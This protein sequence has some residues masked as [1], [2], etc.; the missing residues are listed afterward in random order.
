M[1]NI[2]KFKIVGIEIKTSNLNGRGIQ[3]IGK[4]WAEFFAKNISSQIENKI[5]DEIY[6]I[7]TDY[8]SDYTGEYTCI[9]GMKVNAIDNIPKRLIGRK[10]AGG[11]YQKFIAKGQLPNAVASTWN[12][13][14]SKDNEL[15]RKYSADFEVYGKNSQLGESSEVEIFIAINV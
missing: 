4:L 6:A 14:W 15:D 1:E 5:S 13:I 10:F 8:E 2:E 12:E 7:Y 11:N 9:I 3:D